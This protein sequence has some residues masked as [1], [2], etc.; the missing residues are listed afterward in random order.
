MKYW[1]KRADVPCQ[2]LLRWAKLRTSKYHRWKKR[3]GQVNSHNGK[4]P[5]DWWLE[6]WE[7]QAIIDFHDKH[8][9]EGYRRLTFMML[10]EDIV[11][12][13]PSSTYR[14]LKAAGRLDR[15]NV[16]PSKKGTGFVQPTKNH[17]EWH[18]DVSYINVGGSFYFLISVL[19]GFSRYI[20]HWELR[21]TMKELD[22]ELVIAKAIE[23]H[24]GVSPRII[25]DNGPQ[26]IAKDFKEFVR[27]YGLTHVRT[28]PYYPQ[29]NGKLER[30]H[31]SLKSECIRPSCPATREEAQKRIEKYVNHYNHVRLH[32]AIGYI[33]PADCLAGLSQVIGEERDRKLE[34]ARERRQ[35][36]RATAKQHVA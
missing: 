20:V 10:D 5:R 4:I 29:S 35:Q 30:W 22:V 34:S 25:S 9:L 26:F 23:K 31:G 21:E 13:S 7:K 27:Q 24:P 8:P 3:Y 15:K 1:T 14:V 11:A 19:D 12:V 17:Q 33:T 2:L 36:R 28:S 6:E 16:T 32:S 18:V